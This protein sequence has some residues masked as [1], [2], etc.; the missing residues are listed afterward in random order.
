M[1]SVNRPVKIGITIL[2][3]KVGIFAAIMVCWFAF[4]ASRRRADAGLEHDVLARIRQ[5]SILQ[6]AK[7][8]LTGNS[9]TDK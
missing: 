1:T 8:A 2:N 7:A 4:N 5:L 9:G 6:G 3:G